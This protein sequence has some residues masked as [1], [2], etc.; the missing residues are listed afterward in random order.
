MH[1]IATPFQNFS[2]AV[3]TWVYEYHVFGGEILHFKARY[4]KN[5]LLFIR[6]SII[7]NQIC[8]FLFPN[9]I[10]VAKEEPSCFN[11]LSEFDATFSSYCATFVVA[12]CKEHVQQ[13]PTSHNKTA[14]NPFWLIMI[15][16]IFNF[17]LAVFDVWEVVQV[18][19][20]TPSSQLL[21]CPYNIFT[22]DSNICDIEFQL[23]SRIMS[24]THWNCH[25]SNTKYLFSSVIFW[26][27]KVL[28]VVMCPCLNS[29]SLIDL[30][31]CGFLLQTLWEFE[32]D[33]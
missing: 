8:S 19:F 12:V 23:Y 6:Y 7:C 24:F 28:T 14:L 20:L 16:H 5:C 4:V 3:S 13:H 18:P 30:V 32:M 9:W 10:V 31:E 11:H 27:C 29:M 2:Q 25:T 17:S 26:T 15:A 33:P 22:N 21:A 1:R